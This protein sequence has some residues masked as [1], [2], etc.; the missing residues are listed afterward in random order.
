MNLTIRAFKMLFRTKSFPDKTTGLCI[1]ARERD[2]WCT[3]RSSVSRRKALRHGQC[4]YPFVGK[5]N[6]RE[7]SSVLHE[8][9]RVL[10]NWQIS[11]KVHAWVCV[12]RVVLIRYMNHNLHSWNGKFEYFCWG[13]C[14][15]IYTW[16]VWMILVGSLLST[17]TS[18]C[19]YRKMFH[20]KWQDI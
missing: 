13:C 3:K 12:I 11:R 4:Q 18:Y 10:I 9:G 20:V 7:R 5:K 1:G 19:G 15:L 6:E 17:Q 8:A 2:L 14:I 16:T